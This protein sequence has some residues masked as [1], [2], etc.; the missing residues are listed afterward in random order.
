MLDG[1]IGIVAIR[2]RFCPCRV[3]TALATIA[4]RANAVHRDGERLMRLGRE[5][6]QRDARRQQPLADFG[7]A[8]HLLQRDGLEA[9]GAEIQQVA[10]RHRRAAA[11]TLRIALEHLIAVGGH[12][13]LQRVDQRAVKGMRLAPAAQLVQATHRQRHRISIPG[14]AMQFHNALGDARKTNARNA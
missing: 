14:A 6:A 3:L 4:A 10:Q 7:D 11:H 13:L 12:G 5:R 9:L 8:L 1:G 2:P